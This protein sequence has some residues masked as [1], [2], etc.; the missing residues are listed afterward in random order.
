MTYA[1]PQAARMPT[2]AVLVLVLVVCGAEAAMGLEAPAP[3][4]DFPLSFDVRPVAPDSDEFSSL[5]STVTPIGSGGG[6]YITVSLP[7][8]S[9]TLFID[10][11]DGSFEVYNVESGKEGPRSVPFGAFPSPSRCRSSNV[12]E[13]ADGIGL[14]FN[15]QIVGCTPVPAVVADDGEFSYEFDGGLNV[16]RG[17]DVLQISPPVTAG[18]AVALPERGVHEP[19][20][21]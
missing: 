5:F 2:A 7:G 3:E 15:R 18:A 12:I 8:S 1:L 13:V 9:E 16:A 21:L 6:S 19:H 11:H 20:K 10:F 17:G 14:V 4:A